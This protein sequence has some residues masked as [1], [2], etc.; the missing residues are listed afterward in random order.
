MLR[1]AKKML[2]FRLNSQT[3]V[4]GSAFVFILPM[5]CTVY[6]NDWDKKVP[7]SSEVRR[8]G[9]GRSHYCFAVKSN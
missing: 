6:M 7:S 4:S 8:Y 2:F 5:K 1:I 3:D 9:R